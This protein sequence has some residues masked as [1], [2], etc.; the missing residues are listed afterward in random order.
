MSPIFPVRVLLV[1]EAK[2]SFVHEVRTLQRM[3]GALFA[4]VVMGKPPQLPVN[5]RCELIKSGFVSITPAAQY[6]RDIPRL[7]HGFLYMIRAR[8]WP[9]SRGSARK[10]VAFQH[11]I[12]MVGWRA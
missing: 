3:P 2:V 4:E 11:A 12:A 7:G 5:K 9:F 10:R 6:G 1:Y 8:W